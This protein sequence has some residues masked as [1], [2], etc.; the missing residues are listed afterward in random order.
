MK[1]F[2]YS[3]IILTGLIFMTSCDEQTANPPKAKIVTHTDTTFSDVRSDNYFW[4]RE[5]RNPDVRDYL[6]AENKYTEQMMRHTKPLQK[7]LYKEM[8]GR[9]KETD[10]SVPYQ[11]GAYFYYSRTEQGK[12]Y[13]VHCRKKGSLQAPEEILIDENKLAEGH[14]YFRVGVFQ[15]SPDQS[16]L[17]WSVDTTGGEKYTIYFKN[18][19]TG[20]ILPDQIPDTYYSLAWANDN[21]TVFYN[22]LDEAMRPY[23]LFRHRLGTEAKNDPLVYEEKDEKFFLF[24]FLRHIQE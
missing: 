10:E 24:R 12:Q 8:V 21:K 15:V 3:F 20:E 5:R 14:K 7:A 18:L 9:I 4:L 22:I 11:M 13:R 17:A 16:L 1:Y 23:K 6:E 2:I 19:K